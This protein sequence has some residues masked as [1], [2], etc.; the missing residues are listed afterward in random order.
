MTEGENAVV[1]V[2]R[3]ISVVV[4]V[5]GLAVALAFCPSVHAQDHNVL[6]STPAIFPGGS[7]RGNRPGRDAL[8]ASTRQH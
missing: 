8:G 2:D 1:V 3:I 7:E 6:N 5:S 4:G